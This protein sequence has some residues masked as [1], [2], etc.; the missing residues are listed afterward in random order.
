M[1]AMARLR[2]QTADAFLPHK[3]EEPDRWAERRRIR[4]DEDHEASRGPYD[5]TSRPWWRYPLQALGNPLTR[6]LRLKTSTQVGKTLFLLIA[7][8]Y[9]CE[10][11]PATA[12]VVVPDRIAASEF[13]E[14]LYALADANGITTPP[15]YR[16]NTRRVDIGDMRIWLAWPRSPNTLRG[17]RCK[18]VFRTEIDVFPTTKKTKTAGNAIEASNRRVK[19]FRRYL[20]LDEST[21]IAEDSKID[22]LEGD[23]NRARWFAKCPHCGAHQIAR[24]FAH[25][26]GERAGRGGVAGYRTEAGDLKTAERARR[27]SYYVCQ[28]NGCKITN[29]QKSEFMVGGLMLAKGQKIDDTTG[30]ISGDPDPRIVGVHLWSAHSNDSWGEIAAEFVVAVRDGTMA[31]FFQNTLGLQFQ[32]KGKMPEWR[33]L[34]KRMAG[35]HVRGKVPREAWF[36]TAGGDVQD[37]EVYVSVR[38]WGDRRSSW[39]VDWFVFD[40]ADGDDGEL[41]KSDL[42]Q[43]TKAVLARR[44]AVVGP[45]G[46]PCGNARGREGQRVALM[47]ID[48]N[49]R[50]LDVHNWIKSLGK[51]N[52]VIAMRGEAQVNASKKYQLNTVHESQRPAADGNKTKYTGGLLLMNINPEVFRVDLEDRMAADPTQPGA[53]LVTKDCLDVG[54]F[55]LQQVV[56]EPRLPVKGKDGRNKFERR[57]R[58]KTIAH[59]FW[60]TAVYES[61]AAQR[62]VDDFPGSPGWDAARWPRG[63]T[64][65]LATVAS[66]KMVSRDFDE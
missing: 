45:D 31:D 17:K 37:R 60:D 18:Y 28:A 50:T 35:Y 52:R 30:E 32:H 13:S 6:F 43:I 2:R 25:K 16:R 56:N 4:F 27:D 5:L 38:A 12:M 61:A 48:A 49:H 15:V 42:A 53:W 21:P 11:A 63:E 9:L 22:A 20:I 44:F 34:G 66:G 26:E 3:A 10:N 29:E 33:D 14:R 65:K 41:V 46:K 23:S 62:I 58:D 8:L 19:A 51:T 59:D 24:F 55:F 40:R 39:L 1:S 47:G 7:L 36:L 57:E 54:A 64:N